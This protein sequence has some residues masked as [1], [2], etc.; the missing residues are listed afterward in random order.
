MTHPLI[1]RL[2]RLLR[3]TAPD[4]LAEFRPAADQSDLDEAAELVGE[5]APLWVELHA[6]RDGSPEFPGMWQGLELL[7]LGGSRSIKRIM[8]GLEADGTFDRWAPN[9]WWNPGWVPIFDNHSY[10]TYVIDTVGSFGGEPGQILH[11]MKDGAA[12]PAIAPSLDAFLQVF[13]DLVDDGTLVWK[14]EEGGF[15]S[16]GHALVDELIAERFDGFPKR[17]EA[18]SRRSIGMTRTPK[19]ATRVEC[20]QGF[21][22]EVTDQVWAPGEA[23]VGCAEWLEELGVLAVGQNAFGDADFAALSLV[24]PKSGEVM[25]EVHPAGSGTMAMRWLAERGELVYLV[26]AA[27]R[28]IWVWDKESD[29]TRQLLG[30]F[31]E[32]RMHDAFDAAGRWVV[33]AGE[34]VRLHDLDT[35]EVRSVPVTHSPEV[36]AAI[37][38]AGD[39]LAVHLPDG[40]M[41]IFAIS[42]DAIEVVDEWPVE[43]EKFSR[44]C[45]DPAG[46]VLSAIGWYSRTFERFDQN[47]ESLAIAEPPHS[48]FVIASAAN[49]GLWAAAGYGGPVTIH[50]R[51]GNQLFSDNAHGVSRVHALAFDTTASRLFSGGDDGQI[52]TR[53]LGE[54]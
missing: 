26:N 48:P 3:Q 13:C 21:S 54:G 4:F 7:S 41:R 34:A 24:E 27:G 52:V 38:P 22:A 39:R 53:R 46:Q 9:E 16:R 15:G 36:S 2:E 6:W 5:V 42:D 30:D 49:D 50:D 19:P 31:W 20:A 18:R 43:S 1:E 10:D 33:H 29:S 12:R 47:G 32:T 35:D 25:R 45:F 14:A 28:E 37:A 40:P 17:G 51:D 8:D 44:L 11:W 23:R